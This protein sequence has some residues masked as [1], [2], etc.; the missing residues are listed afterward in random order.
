MEEMFQ[1]YK[2]I[3]EFRLI[4]I[5]EA[6]AADSRR[7][8]GLAKQKGINE[9]KN[10]GERCSTAEMFLKDKE[11][12]IPL[13]IDG[14]DNAA[15][16]DYSAQPDRVFLVRSDGRLAVAADRGPWGF[17][18][19]LEEVEEWLA[20]FKRSGVEP[21]LSEKAIE[22]G[23]RATKKREERLQT[24]VAKQIQKI[25]GSWQVHFESK[26]DDLIERIELDVKR[27]KAMGIA[28]IGGSEYQV[29]QL[30]FDGAYL[31]L[32]VADKESTI[33]FY[34]E[35]KDDQI[36]GEFRKNGDSYQCSWSND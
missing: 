10:F 3:A 21:E 34:G 20:D 19:A 11:F 17:A 35:F 18:P 36:V 16:K 13:L 7:P 6:H 28:S 31:S 27:N 1:S 29:E 12:N 15:N 30:R 4:Y 26:Q 2:D 9:H 8:T 22:A 25:S 24:E 5:R 23:D 14:M 33:R 32:S